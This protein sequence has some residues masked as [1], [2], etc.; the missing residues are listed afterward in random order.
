MHRQV[1]LD[2]EGGRANAH[3]FFFILA[4]EWHARTYNIQMSC[5]S[6]KF[7]SIWV[8]L[9]SQNHPFRPCMGCM[10]WL[11]HQASTVS[12]FSFSFFVHISLRAYIYKTG[13]CVVFIVDRHVRDGTWEPGGPALTW[14][15]HN[16]FSQTN[17]KSRIYCVEKCGRMP[18]AISH[19]VTSFRHYKSI[20]CQKSWNL[21]SQTVYIYMLTILIFEVNWFCLVLHII[22]RAVQSLSQ[23]RRE[24]Q[25]YS[26]SVEVNC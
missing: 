25:F 4:T 1:A 12:F 18:A 10:Q 7:F 3:V 8:M 21:F 9:S 5:W 22:R 20:A 15:S 13:T 26:F 17:T 23:S 14:L 16:L 2:L 6:T 11:L 19:C 24:C